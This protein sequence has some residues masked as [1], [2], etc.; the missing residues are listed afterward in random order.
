VHDT[1]FIYNVNIL[2]GTGNLYFH[3][4]ILPTLRASLLFTKLIKDHHNIILQIKEHHYVV[5]KFSIIL[6]LA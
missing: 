6:L 3:Y 4:I 1:T 5:K 2:K